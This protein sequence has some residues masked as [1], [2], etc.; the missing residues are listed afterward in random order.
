[1]YNLV[2]CFFGFFIRILFGM[3]FFK[4][5][6]FIGQFYIYDC[7]NSFVVIYY[8]KKQ[9]QLWIWERILLRGREMI[10]DDRNKYNLNVL[11]IL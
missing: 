7:I 9:Y 5:I 11:Y 2:V 10:R 6:D 4:M 1:M 3:R 8:E